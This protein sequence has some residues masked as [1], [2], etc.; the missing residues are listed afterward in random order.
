MEIISAS[1]PKLIVWHRLAGIV[2]II[3]TAFF[4]PIAAPLVG[5]IFLVVEV[6]FDR[7]SAVQK[8]SVFSI[9]FAIVILVLLTII[10][11]IFFLGT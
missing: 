10:S 7:R 11:F 9:V 1:K 8:A 3:V 2:L 4:V 5:L 6:I